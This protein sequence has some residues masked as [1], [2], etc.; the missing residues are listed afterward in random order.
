M[1][2]GTFEV[3]KYVEIPGCRGEDI[4]GFDVY[5]MPQTS[6]IYVSWTQYHFCQF[7]GSFVSYQDIYGQTFQV[8]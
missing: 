6:D 1:E 4:F 2:A 3:I 8:Q 7:N 5:N